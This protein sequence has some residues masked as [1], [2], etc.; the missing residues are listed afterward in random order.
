[1]HKKLNDEWYF[2]KNR[3]GCEGMFPSSYI[4]VKVPIRESSSSSSSTKNHQSQAMTST[5]IPKSQ[6]T[7]KA[8]ALY[9]FTAEAPEDLSLQVN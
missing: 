7:P 3:R 6:P 5:P 8:R 1:M 9:N 2:G 4:N